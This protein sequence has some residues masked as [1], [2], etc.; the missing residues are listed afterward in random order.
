MVTGIELINTRARSNHT[1]KFS[2]LM[3][4]FSE[5]N[6]KECFESLDGK[7]ALGIDRISKEEYGQNLEENL[8]TLVNSLKTMSY[9][10]KPVRRV[11]ILKE[12]GTTRPLGISCFEDKI[13]QEMTRRI[14]EAIYE[15]VFIETSYGFRPGRNCHDALRK[16]DSELMSKPV[17]W[18]VDMDISRFFDTMPHDEI[19][20][21]LSE[22]IS[23]SKFLRIVSRQLKSGI[24]YPS[25]V[26]YSE[27]GTQQGS[28]CKA[29]HN[30][31][32]AK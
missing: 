22:R 12:D 6:L 24:N 28:L 4:H 2:A 20:T 27:L 14:L 19:L 1:E 32:Y 3:H 7:K 15:P 10:P 8:R 11:E 25:G 30:E 18:I 13:I 9:K 29:L 23:D 16:L 5:D 21:L 26:E 31:P 17:N